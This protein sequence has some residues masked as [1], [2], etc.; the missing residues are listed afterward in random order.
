MCA[1]YFSN[2]GNAIKSEIR[3]SARI[4]KPIIMS[5]QRRF[6]TIPTAL[7][8]PRHLVW[9]D[10]AYLGK[11]SVFVTVDEK[12]SHRVCKKNKW[13]GWGSHGVGEVLGTWQI[14]DDPSLRFPLAATRLEKKSSPVKSVEIDIHRRTAVLGLPSH[15]PLYH[16]SFVCQ[17]T[18]LPSRHQWISYSN[19]QFFVLVLNLDHHS[20]KNITAIYPSHLCM[21]MEIQTK[22]YQK[23]W[24]WNF[25]MCLLIK[26]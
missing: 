6:A 12:H 1:S 11:S 16:I 14:I 2:V 21:C 15:R 22:W 18:Y 23:K 20:M 7:S 4:G 10:F 25:W 19:L 3:R 17:Q 24:V 5:I 13:R 9:L 8:H 26:L